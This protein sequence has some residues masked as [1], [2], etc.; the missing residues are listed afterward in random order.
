MML[1]NAF[2]SIRDLLG[3]GRIDIRKA[4]VYNKLNEW[5]PAR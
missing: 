1:Q 5:F 2:L 3:L 4:L